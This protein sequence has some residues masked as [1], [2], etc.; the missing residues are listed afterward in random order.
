MG[1]GQLRAV[2]GSTARRDNDHH[3]NAEVLS[4]SRSTGANIE[5]AGGYR[6]S[7]ADTLG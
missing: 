2:A 5:V 1:A 6:L 4:T 7:L 3:G